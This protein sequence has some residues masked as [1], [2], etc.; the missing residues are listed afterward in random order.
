[1]MKHSRKRAL[2]GKDLMDGYRVLVNIV[3]VV[4]ISCALHEIP[5]LGHVLHVLTHDL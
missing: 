1:M 4:H 2:E 5:G 3:N